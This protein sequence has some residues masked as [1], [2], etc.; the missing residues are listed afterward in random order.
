MSNTPETN[1]LR[2]S[3]FKLKACNSVAY[4]EMVMLARRFERERDEARRKLQSERDL[5]THLLDVDAICQQRDEA[6]RER[7]VF[8]LEMWK[9]RNAVETLAGATRHLLADF[10]GFKYAAK[11]IHDFGKSHGNY[12]IE[13]AE[14]TL[15]EV[16]SL[17]AISVKGGLDE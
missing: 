2:D 10:K 4:Q 7:D 3:L 12:S 15:E 5:P 11:E 9:A 1:E 16:R 17:A 13:R 8:K 14:K 6:R